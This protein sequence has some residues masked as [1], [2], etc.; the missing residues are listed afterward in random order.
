MRAFFTS[1]CSLFGFRLASPVPAGEKVLRCGRA[2]AFERLGFRYNV[3]GLRLFL[4]F[5]PLFW[6]FVSL[7]FVACSMLDVSFIKERLTPF[8]EVSHGKI[9]WFFSLLT[10]NPLLLVFYLVVRFSKSLRTF[11]CERALVFWLLWAVCFLAQW[12]SPMRLASLPVEFGSE[13]RWTQRFAANVSQGLMLGGTRVGGGRGSQLPLKTENNSF[14]G[15]RVILIWDES[16]PHSRPFAAGLADR[17]LFDG[18][19]RY[20]LVKQGNLADVTALSQTGT[21]LWVSFEPVTAMP[22]IPGI[23]QSYHYDVAL[24]ENGKVYG[25][26]EDKQVKAFFFGL[27]TMDGVYRE[28]GA[29]MVAKPPPIPGFS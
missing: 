1:T 24:Y 12:V 29:E 18:R 13:V 27:F 23:Y 16:K 6:M 8:A 17:L 26:H 15:E 20:A 25:A 22:P 14:L 19:T 21:V 7:M 9:F 5:L 2:P 11:F 28:I 10:F 3:L 4:S